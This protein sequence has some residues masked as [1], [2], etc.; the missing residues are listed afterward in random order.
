MSP[1]G[2]RHG[3]GEYRYLRTWTRR[4]RS[5]DGWPGRTW[6]RAGI[7]TSRGRRRSQ[8]CRRKK[9]KNPDGCVKYYEHANKFPRI[10]WN[11]KTRRPVSV[12]GRPTARYHTPAAM[13]VVVV[14][15]IVVVPARAYRHRTR[16]A[17]GGGGTKARTHE[18]EMT[19][20]TTDQYAACHIKTKSKMAARRR[21]FTA[22]RTITLPSPM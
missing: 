19:T 20:T 3:S 13:A 21:N 6:A 9:T 11:S 8:Y 4:D 18:H 1:T 10:S 12:A 22:T 7:R 16:Q 5:T 2:T 15:V 14:I 17:M